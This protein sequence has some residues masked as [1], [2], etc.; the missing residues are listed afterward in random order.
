MIHENQERVR[1][2]IRQVAQAAYEHA[3]EVCGNTAA[4]RKLMAHRKEWAAE[5]VELTETPDN[6]VWTELM[7][8]LTLDGTLPA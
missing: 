5:M 1:A 4:G 3:A 8:Q 7:G 2:L 6:D